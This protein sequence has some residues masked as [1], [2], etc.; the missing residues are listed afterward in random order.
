MPRVG[1]VG[2]ACRGAC[3]EMGPVVDG[4]KATLAGGYIV[5]FRLG[6]VSMDINVSMYVLYVLHVRRSG[7]LLARLAS[8]KDGIANIRSSEYYVV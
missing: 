6:P 3:G 4:V 5:A 7:L 2:G 1:P 8:L